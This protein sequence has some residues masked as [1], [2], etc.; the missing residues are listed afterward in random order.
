MCRGFGEMGKQRELGKLG[1]MR[2]MRAGLLT[3]G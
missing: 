2:E 1:K 3:S